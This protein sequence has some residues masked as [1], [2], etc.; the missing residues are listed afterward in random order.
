MFS[1]IYVEQDIQDCEYTKR[2]LNFF[3]NVP[4]EKIEKYSE[5]FNKYKKPYLQKRNNLN[6]FVAK[7]QGSLLKDAPDAYGLSGEPHYYYV[8]AY[9]C[10]YEC[11]YCYLQGYFS[12]PDLVLFTNHNEILETIENKIKEHIIKNKNG[13]WFHAG[14]YSDSLALSHITGEL[15]NYHKLFKR[16]PQAFLELRT[17]SANIAE[18]KKL[19][20]LNNL[21]I[22]FSLSPQKQVKT[23][24][25]KTAPL[26]AR[27]NAIKELHRLGH[28]I[29]IHLDPIIID[30]N[31]KN[32]YIELLDQLNDAIALREVD[33][34]SVG[35][36]RFS[37]EVFSQVKQNY[38]NSKYLYSELVKGKD[39]KFKYPRP[40]RRWVLN[41]VKSLCVE[42]GANEKSVY[43]CMED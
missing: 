18:I 28:P 10:I 12:S 43:L 25:L 14:E 5:I 31:T 34:I 4:T 41:T 15:E 38:P 39:G 2:I 26:K 19:D 17:K 21:I 22:S 16:Y 36:V 30:E 37:K 24:D 40:L 13:I 9:N 33:Y 32:D 7:K 8:H 20:P 1:K 6:L 23:H 35:V 3:K 42:R 29:G 27:L 11:D